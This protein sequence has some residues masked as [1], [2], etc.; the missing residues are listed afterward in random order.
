MKS[1]GCVVISTQDVDPE[2]SCNTEKVWSESK[3]APEMLRFTKE[4]GVGGREGRRF[5]TGGCA[6][7]AMLAL[8]SRYVR[9][10]SH[11]PHCQEGL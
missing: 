3:I 10:G 4:T 2:V 6:V 9:T 5:E 7:R 11:S 1:E 8:S